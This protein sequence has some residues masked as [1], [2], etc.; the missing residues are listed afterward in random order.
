MDPR[1]VAVGGESTGGGLAACLTQQLRDTGT[2]Q[3][4]AQWLFEP[5]LDEHTTANHTLDEVGH[6]VWTNTANRVGWSAYLAHTPDNPTA[7]YAVAARRDDLRG[8]PPAWIGV[9]DIDLFHDE[10]AQYAARLEDPGV[11]VVF[12]VVPGAPHGFE[13]WAADASVTREFLDRARTWLRTAT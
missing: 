1:R 13:N 5:M 6:W 12:D 11:P 8:L 10:N 3:P 4:V 2:V 7:P 9:G